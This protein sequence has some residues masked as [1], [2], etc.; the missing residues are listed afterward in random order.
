M[1]GT[2]SLIIIRNLKNNTIQKMGPDY[3]EIYKNIMNK[4][5][6]LLLSSYFMN[7]LGANKNFKLTVTNLTLINNNIKKDITTLLENNLVS[8]KELKHQLIKIKGEAG[9]NNKT[10]L[11]CKKVFKNRIFMKQK[12]FKIQDNNSEKKIKDKLFLSKTEIIVK[13]LKNIFCSNILPSNHKNKLRFIKEKSYINKELG[14]SERKDNINSGRR[15]TS[16]SMIMPICSKHNNFIDV[17]KL[18]K[19]K[20]K[21]YLKNNKENQIYISIVKKS[22]IKR[23]NSI[24]NFNKLTNYSSYFKKKF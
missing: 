6:P 11:N 15:G 7:N 23:N 24:K 18:L 5:K 10:K 13:N 21:K 20:D 2:D 1:E 22:S 19:L 3:D 8:N 9:N 14:Y 4:P 16:R 12:Y 17:D